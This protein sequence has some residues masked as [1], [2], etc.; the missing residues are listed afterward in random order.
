MVAALIQ[1]L[2]L[3]SGVVVI[4]LIS[5]KHRRL[6]QLC[7][8]LG[9]LTEPLWFITAWQH[10]QWGIYLMSLWYMLACVH[11]LWVNRRP[12]APSLS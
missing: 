9:L 7:F 8:V 12:D 1:L 5:S 2:I 4:I 10:D 6:R 11:G 3:L